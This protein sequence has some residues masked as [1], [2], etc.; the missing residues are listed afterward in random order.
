VLSP[1]LGDPHAAEEAPA[2][3]FRAALEKLDSW[4]PRGQTLFAWLCRIAINKATDLHRERAR[5]GRALASFEELIG[6]LHI[7]DDVSFALA[8]NRFAALSR[9]ALQRLSERYRSA[10]ELPIREEK[11]RV[12]CASALGITVGN[13]DV[14]LLRSLRAFRAA[15]IERFGNEERP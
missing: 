2:E 6:P 10:I 5:T 1:R 11:E 9:A 8:Q 15:W 14:L 13:F 4:E 12:D 7:P 3:T